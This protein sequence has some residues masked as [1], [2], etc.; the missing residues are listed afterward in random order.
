[1]RGDDV[2]ANDWVLL[3]G[4]VGAFLTSL[5]GGVRFVL[6]RSDA[7]RAI[8]DAKI[9]RLAKRNAEISRAYM[10]AMQRIARLEQIILGLGAELPE[11][12]GEKLEIPIDK[13]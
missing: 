7:M 13:N 6:G 1:M 11:R 10:H 12:N 4:G 9:Q 3:L 2:T 5:G 8:Y